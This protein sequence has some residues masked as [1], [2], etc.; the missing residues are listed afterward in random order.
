MR[1]VSDFRSAFKERDFKSIEVLEHACAASC[2]YLDMVLANTIKFGVISF[3]TM[4]TL[5]RFGNDL[6]IAIV[7]V[8]RTR[9][10]LRP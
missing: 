7:S 10:N 2:V 4:D 6:I 5:R 3:K 1:E 9:E 8:N